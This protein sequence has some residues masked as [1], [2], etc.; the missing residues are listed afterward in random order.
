MYSQRHRA[1]LLHA[2]EK[3]HHAVGDNGVT[4]TALN[5]KMMAQMEN[6]EKGFMHAAVI[7]C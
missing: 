7:E 6:I 4:K 1:S 3:A 5:S 2:P